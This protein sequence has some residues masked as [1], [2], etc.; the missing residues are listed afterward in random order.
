[1][2]GR[3]PRGVA[4]SRTTRRGPMGM[5]RS[6]V[7]SVTEPRPAR[8]RQR[9]TVARRGPTAPAR[10]QPS[11]PPAT[12]RRGI[13]D[14]APPPAPHRPARRPLFILPGHAVADAPLREDVCRL[15]DGVAELPAQP[16]DAGTREPG[17]GPA[18]PAPHLAQQRIV[19]GDP[20]RAER[21]DPQQIVRGRRQRHRAPVGR[22]P[23]VRVIDRELAPRERVGSAAPATRCPDPR[24]GG[25]A[26][27]TRL[28]ALANPSSPTAG[29]K[30]WFVTALV[31]R[32][33][34]RDA[35]VDKKQARV[36]LYSHRVP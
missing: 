24:L 12:A 18:A 21:E 6:P 1:M 15:A 8:P 9:S 27:D 11:P 23:E 4:R 25:R 22:E 2:P 26:P 3:H 30:A 10:P 31:R 29:V 20:D 34:R 32:P 7:R 33:A 13:G 28:Y 5:P 14:R 16:P 35:G 36:S 17:V 19:G